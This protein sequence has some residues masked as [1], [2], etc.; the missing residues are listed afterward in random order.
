MR[1]DA[2]IV[3]GSS[4]EEPYFLGSMQQKISELG[5]SF[6]PLPKSSG[7][8]VG[9]MAKLDSISLSCESEHNESP[10]LKYANSIT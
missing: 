8:S 2:I 3:D 1:P 9:W 10:I 5:I 7:S 4:A 6:I